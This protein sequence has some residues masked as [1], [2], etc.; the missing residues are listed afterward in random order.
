MFHLKPTR[1]EL[2]AVGSH[3]G[4][5]HLAG[6]LSQGAPSFTICHAVSQQDLTIS[7]AELAPKYNAHFWFLFFLKYVLSSIARIK[8]EQH[9]SINK[10]EMAFIQEV[11]KQNELQIQI[12]SL[13]Q[14]Y[15]IPARDLQI[16]LSQEMDLH[17][18][19]CFIFNAFNK[20]FSLSSAA[21]V[22][23]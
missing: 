5:Q 8:E 7:D 3:L 15:R 10:R 16:K 11:E 6:L 2:Y 23:V 21:F 12:Q 19:V 22:C 18:E 1:Y 4:K 13:S 17:I 14:T 9:E 20:V